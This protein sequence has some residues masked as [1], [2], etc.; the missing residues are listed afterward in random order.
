MGPA[1]VLLLLMASVLALSVREVVLFRRASHVI[2]RRALMLRLA[3][4]GLLL[5]V[6]AMLLY[7]ITGLSEANPGRALAY[8][9]ACLGLFLV[10]IAI[11]LVDLRALRKL[12]HDRCEELRRRIMGPPGDNGRHRQPRA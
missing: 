8:W 12:H 1:A 3:N 6:L 5:V 9:G 4:G 7:G 2:H 11:A 10:S